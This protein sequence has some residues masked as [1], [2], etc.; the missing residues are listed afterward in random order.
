MRVACW[1]GRNSVSPNAKRSPNKAPR[2]EHADVE[3]ARVHQ[4]L[5][6]ARDVDQ[7]S[8]K[9]IARSRRRSVL[10]AKPARL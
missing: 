6:G 10:R 3:P 8:R 9:L 5:P 2:Q 1:S 4:V 7:R